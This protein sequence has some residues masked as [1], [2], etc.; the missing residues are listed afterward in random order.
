VRGLVAPRRG[1]SDGKPGRR[2]AGHL[3]PRVV[4]ASLGRFSEGARASVARGNPRTS[5]ASRPD[6]TCR[7]RGLPESFGLSAP[8]PAT[9]RADS[10]RARRTPSSC[11][12]DPNRSRRDPPRRSHHARVRVS[13]S[14]GRRESPIKRSCTS[15]AALAHLA[16]NLERDRCRED[17]TRADR[18]A[19]RRARAFP[20]IARSRPSQDSPAELY[21]A[22][23]TRRKNLRAR[24]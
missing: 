13:E 11:A 14:S 7:T 5:A 3:A 6:S 10:L 24:P 4:T 17:P 9:S 12:F 23:A 18:S 20:P 1:L 2:A 19:W 21:L 8:L 22:R 15:R 16:G